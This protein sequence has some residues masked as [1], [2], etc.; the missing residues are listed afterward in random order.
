MQ[1]RSH[2]QF[3][4]CSA[5]LYIQTNVQVTKL[6]R[7]D[8]YSVKLKGR[9]EGAGQVR[10]VLHEVRKRNDF[11]TKIGVTHSPAECVL[12]WS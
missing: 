6:Q 3:C 8:G 5:H 4:L 11:A 10:Q 7:S 2:P 1:T 12:G 9:S